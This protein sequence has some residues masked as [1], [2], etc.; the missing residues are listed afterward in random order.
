MPPLTHPPTCLTNQVSLTHPTKCG[1]DGENNR[2]EETL[3]RNAKLPPP[4]LDERVR[5]KFVNK[6][7]E[8]KDDVIKTLLATYGREHIDL[9]NARCSRLN[10]TGLMHAAGNGHFSTVRCLLK[11]GADAR[12]TALQGETAMHLAASEGLSE[13]CVMLY[14]HDPQLL[15][16]R[17][18]WNTTPIMRSIDQGWAHTTKTLYN[19][20]AALETFGPKC[21]VRRYC[22]GMRWPK[23]RLFELDDNSTEGE[24][25]TECPLCTYGF[26]LPEET[27]GEGHMT[28][29]SALLPGEFYPNPFLAEPTDG[30][31]PSRAGPCWSPVVNGTRL[32][33]NGTG[34]AQQ[35]PRFPPMLA[36][37][38]ID[39]TRR[40]RTRPVNYPAD[41]HPS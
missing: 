4:T 19:L 36:P 15:H 1:N 11:R 6:C 9:V 39:E 5:A 14:E 28:D 12:A 2:L 32:V 3:T 16:L 34:Q 18:N 23:M 25:S 35:W 29:F 40:H 8:G 7:Q 31:G 37:F 30:G 26:I 13:V 20:G 24:A 10:L 22:Q 41:T 38:Q 33:Y 27:M 21:T 17:D